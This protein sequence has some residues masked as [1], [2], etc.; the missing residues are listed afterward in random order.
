MP[1]LTKYAHV[2]R[3]RR[4]RVARLPEGVVQRVRISDRYVE[5]SRLR[6]REARYDDGTVVHKL[7][8]KVRLTDGPAEVACTTLYLDDAEWQLLR[9]LPARVLTKTRHLVERAGRRIAIDALEDGTLLAECDEGGIPAMPVPWLDV[10]EDVTHD[11]A[12][13]GAALAR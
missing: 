3:E 9:S 7:G 11:E 4:F 12:W 6:L 8:Q 2:E 5:H 13:T 10:I 1:D